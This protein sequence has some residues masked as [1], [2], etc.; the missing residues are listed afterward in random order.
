MSSINR[1]HW[2][3]SDGKFIIRRWTDVCNWLRNV[4]EIFWNI[5]FDS[6]SFKSISGGWKGITSN[7]CVIYGIES[8]L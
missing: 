1:L 8:I 3:Q 4:V 7:E 5:E 6:N 2:R